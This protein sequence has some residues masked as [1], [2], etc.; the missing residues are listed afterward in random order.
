MLFG[1]EQFHS[2]DHFPIIKQETKIT[3]S[4]EEK[5]LSYQKK[6]NLNLGLH[7]EI[8]KVFGST[9]PFF[10]QSPPFKFAEQ[11]FT[12]VTTLNQLWK[13]QVFC[14]STW[15]VMLSHYRIL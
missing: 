15:N 5:N 11:K 13:V 10:C 7:F 3:V 12:L 6:G 4:V 8:H 1:D 14:W 2:K 9:S